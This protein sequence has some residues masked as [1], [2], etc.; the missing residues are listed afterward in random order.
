MPTKPQVLKTTS[1]TRSR[2]FEIEALDLRFS[3]GVERTFERIASRG[4]GAVMILPLRDPDTLV[5][6]NEYAAGLEDYRL[7]LPKGLMEPGE[8]P[9]EAANRELMEEIGCGARKLT[10]LKTLT[11]SPNYMGHKIHLLLAEDLYEESREGDEPEPLEVID[12]PLAE[13]DELIMRPDF[14][15][16]RVMAA[17]LLLQRHLQARL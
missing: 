9:E 13:L 6:I 2:L 15:E 7:T 17:L 12:V 14:D 16:A 8:A 11:T 10:L 3:N 1:V 4:F 5:L